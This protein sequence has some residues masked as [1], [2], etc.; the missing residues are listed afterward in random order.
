MVNKKLT[1]TLATMAAALLPTAVLAENVAIYG[2]AGFPGVGVG[3]GYGL[4]EN[5]TLRGDFTTMGRISRDFHHRAFDYEAK[6]KSD[7]LNVNADYFPFENN[8]FRLTTGLGF[9]RT[10]LT[11]TGRSEGKST[12]TFKIGGKTYSVD[13]N[14]TDTLNAKTT[15]PKVSP[16]FGVGYGHDVQRKKAGEWGFTA[17]LGFYAGKPKTT[18]H[19]NSDLYDKL[20]SSQLSNQSADEARA[21][22]DRRIAEETQKVKDKTEKLKVIPVFN[23]GFTYNF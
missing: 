13:L 6:L 3:V 2:K 21:E 23:V 4:N 15:Y 9:G 19:I 12:Q 11:A 10:E 7:K 20:V 1:Y 18:V 5:V 17:D 22:L 16:Y 14:S 8:A